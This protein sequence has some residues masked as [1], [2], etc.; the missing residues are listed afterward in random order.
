MSAKKS[1]LGKGLS[2]LLE[3]ADTDITIRSSSSEKS[4]FT[5]GN[6]CFIKANRIETNPFQPRTHFNKE[7][8]LEL[9]SS[10]KEH[11]IIQPITVR[12]IGNDKFQIIS[13]ERRYKAAQI[14]G[15]DEI[16]SYIRIADDQSML[17]MAIIE[18]IQRQDL[19]AIEIGL[20]YQRLLE[21]CNLTQEE[22]SSR[23]GK[24]R[25]TI[26]NYLR[27][28]QLPD[29][30]QAGIRDQLISM[31]HARALLSFKDPEEIIK[32]YQEIIK[33]HLSVRATENL[34]KRKKSNN[35]IPLTLSRYEKRM[36][37]ELSHQYQTKIKIDK[38]N[39]GKGKIVINFD[40]EIEMNRIIDLL[41]K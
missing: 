18:N 14:A 11:G 1:A 35:N 21:E 34:G 23:I 38:S 40:N 13:G 30:I 20:S 41:E 19:N 10:I 8:I 27:I 29:E 22:L 36:Q 2:A 16:P 32:A 9:S 24:N 26:S 5:L 39:K 7:S 6:I 37:D 25:S 4:N 17:E 12:K 28:L 33:N 3:N 31:G 15:L